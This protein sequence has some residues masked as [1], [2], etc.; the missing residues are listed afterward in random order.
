MEGKAAAVGHRTAGL[1]VRELT[2]LPIQPVAGEA[3][4]QVAAEL[5]A[6]SIEVHVKPSILRPPGSYDARRR[7]LRADVLLRRVA[8]ASERPVVGLTDADCYAPPLNF[9]FGVANLRGNTAVVS[10]ARLRT[11]ANASTFMTRAMKEIFH[12]AGHGVGLRHCGN[13]RCVMHFSNSLAET[14]SKGER[15]CATCLRQLRGGS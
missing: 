10:L 7:Q 9:V 1:P 2:L 6:R 11:R 5:R 4:A 14:D 12:E 8:E 3:V 15:L 13:P